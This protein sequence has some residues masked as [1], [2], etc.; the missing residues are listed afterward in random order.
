MNINCFP[1]L[2]SNGASENWLKFA[3]Q[4]WMT[5][6]PLEGSHAGFLLNIFWKKYIS[7]NAWLFWCP[8]TQIFFWFKEF[9]QKMIMQSRTPIGDLI[10]SQGQS[11]TNASDQITFKRKKVN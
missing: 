6:E 7:E 4:F 1:N 11:K 10:K 8:I 5:I 9:T 3:I 2:G